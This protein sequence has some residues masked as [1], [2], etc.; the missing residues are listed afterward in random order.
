M[1]NSHRPQLGLRKTP[2]IH[3]SAVVTCKYCGNTQLQWRETDAGF[4][5]FSLDGDR[6]ICE[7]MTKQAEYRR[8]R[9]REREKEL[10]TT[11]VNKLVKKIA[12]EMQTQLDTKN[13]EYLWDR[14]EVMSMLERASLK[15]LLQIV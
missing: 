7:G 11:P 15:A 1:N 8:E 2:T 3:R 14:E 5:L 13:E 4:K 6:H 10:D 12:E 9:E